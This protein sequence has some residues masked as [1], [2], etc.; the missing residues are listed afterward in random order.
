M[1]DISRIDLYDYLYNITYDV[2]SKNVYRMYAPQELTKSDTE[3][4]FLVLRVGDI[5]DNGEFHGKAYGMARCY[6]TAYVPPK[7]RGRLD[8]AKYKA[9]EDGINNVIRNASQSS[10]PA[11]GVDEESVLSM[12]AAETSNANNFYLTFIKS[13]VVY[14]FNVYKQDKDFSND[15][16]EDFGRLQ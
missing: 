3:D 14:L 10:N 6:I 11:Y 13:F 15:F 5:V 7:T 4:G 12:D 9:F 8:V 2:V 1:L 16:N